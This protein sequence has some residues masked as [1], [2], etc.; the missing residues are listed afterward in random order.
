VDSLQ[1][2]LVSIQKEVSLTKNQ[3]TDIH[4]ELLNFMSTVQNKKEC[5][6]IHEKL[7][8]MYVSHSE[9][10]PIRAFLGMICLAAVTTIATAFFNLILR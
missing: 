3:M 6:A 2:Q 10:A 9:I 7:E 8:K 4:N 1:K 5:Q